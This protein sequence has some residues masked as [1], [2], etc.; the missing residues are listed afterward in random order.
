LV[1]AI[2]ATAFIAVFYAVSELA[3]VW[4]SDLLGN[5]IGLLCTG[6]LI[7]LID[8][9]Q[10]V[11]KRASDVAMPNTESTPQYEAYR[12][13]QVYEAAVETALQ[14]GDVSDRERRMLESLIESLRIDPEAAE[15][16][17]SDLR[18]AR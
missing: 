16:V 8:P 3:A 5:V 9:I 14:E 6:V 1:R 12:K 13:L 18:S 17:E 10:R 11:A 15:R 7:V 2:I 4:L